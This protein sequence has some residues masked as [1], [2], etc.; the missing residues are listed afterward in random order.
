VTE[1]PGGLKDDLEKD[2]LQLADEWGRLRYVC[3]VVGGLPSTSLPPRAWSSLVAAVEITAQGETEVAEVVSAA[4]RIARLLQTIRD[5]SAGDDD[6]RR[7]ERVSI[8]VR[9]ATDALVAPLYLRVHGWLDGLHRSLDGDRPLVV[10]ADSVAETST[11]VTD[12]AVAASRC[13]IMAAV[14]AH[15]LGDAERVE[16]HKGRAE[17]LDVLARS[18][19][20]ALRLLSDWP[21]RVDAVSATI[22]ALGQAYAE[23]GAV[24][25]S[26]PAVAPTL[27]NVGPPAGLTELP[28]RVAAGD[29]AQRAAHL[30][31]AAAELGKGV[32][33]L[34][35]GTSATIGTWQKIGPADTPDLQPLV[36]AAGLVIERAGAVGRSLG[37]ALSDLDD[38]RAQAVEQIADS[39]LAAWETVVVNAEHP[40]AP[41]TGTPGKGLSG[42]GGAGPDTTASRASA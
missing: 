37:E 39:L 10:A 4:E 2:A 18:T 26:H 28:Q 27:R 32:R 7:F 3:S 33:D 15:R 24:L 40:A 23:L 9:D 41:P 25:T 11:A 21:Q 14:V 36:T 16:A 42:S 19:V 30:V 8:Q 12:V 17:A 6:L 31:T 13:I 38:A 29:R 20:A 1:N 22:G 34:I 35:T 5:G